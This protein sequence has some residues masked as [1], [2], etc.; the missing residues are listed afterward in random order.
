MP[1]HPPPRVPR[2]GPIRTLMLALYSAQQTATCSSPFL[3]FQRDSA[4]QTPKHQLHATRMD[5]FPPLSRRHP[6]LPRIVSRR[7]G[8]EYSTA[9]S[10]PA[11]AS[12]GCHR[13]PRQR[14]PAKIWMATHRTPHLAA[15]TTS[16]R[17]VALLLAPSPASPCCR[18][19]CS[20][21]GHGSR[22]RW[23]IEEHARFVE[24]QL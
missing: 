6:L 1:P 23:S 21:V 2:L 16:Y 3:S 11:R 18:L 22:E 8:D 9:A 15:L 20:V 14:L 12:L 5:H 10:C 7:D 17:R 4:Q 24:F 19:L 13:L